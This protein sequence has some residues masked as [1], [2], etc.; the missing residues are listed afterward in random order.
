MKIN[1]QIG[2]M[3]VRRTETTTTTTKR[4]F[5]HMDSAAEFFCCEIQFLSHPLMEK[6][7]GTEANNQTYCR[8]DAFIAESTRTHSRTRPFNLNLKHF[9]KSAKIVRRALDL[10][11]K[12][13]GICIAMCGAR[14]QNTL[15]KKKEKEEMNFDIINTH[16]SQLIARR[17]SSQPSNC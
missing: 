3:C 8:A 12:I 15:Q 1:D 6:Q 17:D 4:N 2:G 5:D 14:T 7:N 13:N 16:T 9:A 11:H 10:F